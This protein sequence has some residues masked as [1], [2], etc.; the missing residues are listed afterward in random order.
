MFF[1]AVYDNY[2]NFPEP[3]PRPHATMLPCTSKK[4]AQSV[5]I[6]LGHIRQVD[7]VV[8]IPNARG[9][10][11]YLSLGDLE[12]AWDLSRIADC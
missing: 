8:R 5:A 12:N 3:R 7:V 11:A 9:G 10:F 6:A 2:D 4:D 1:V